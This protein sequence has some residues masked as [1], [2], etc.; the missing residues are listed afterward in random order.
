MTWKLEEQNYEGVL[1]GRAREVGRNPEEHRNQKISFK[2]RI[3]IGIKYQLC[4][5]WKISNGWEMFL[6][7]SKVKLSCDN[8]KTYIQLI[9]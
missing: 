4:F 5:I 2:K 1:E 3:V 9:L 6:Y 7:T 8:N